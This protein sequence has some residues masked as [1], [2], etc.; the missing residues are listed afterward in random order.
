MVEN[1][2]LTTLDL[3]VYKHKWIPAIAKAL[4]ATTDSEMALFNNKEAILALMMHHEMHHVSD[5]RHDD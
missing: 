3:A 4:F 5:E 2:K 1:A